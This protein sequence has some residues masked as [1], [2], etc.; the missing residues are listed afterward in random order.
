MACE[1]PVLLIEEDKGLSRTD[2][3]HWVSPNVEQASQPRR[4]TVSGTVTPER[5][6]AEY[7]KTRNFPTY[8]AHPGRSRQY[9]TLITFRRQRRFILKSPPDV[10][11][12]RKFGRVTRW[13]FQEP[14]S[15]R[16]TP[17]VLSHID[18]LVP[19]NRLRHYPCR[20]AIGR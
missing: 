14:R 2:L 17:F 16:G 9:R 13:R 18:L 3:S 11:Y 15:L 12:P 8:R 6:F 4:L 7:C 5:L 20:C 19:L 10:G 1:P